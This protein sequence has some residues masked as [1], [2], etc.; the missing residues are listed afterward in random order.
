MGLRI[1]IEILVAAFILTFTAVILMHNLKRR[2][3]S[4]KALTESE[5]RFRTLINGMS[6]FICIKDS[7]G[8]LVD[9]ND[10]VVKLL[11]LDKTT[12]KGLSCEDIA[13]EKP[14]LKPLID[15]IKHYEEGIWVSKESVSFEEPLTLAEG[16]SGL[17]DFTMLP[18]FK[19]NGEK[20]GVIII[21]KDLTDRKKTKEDLQKN[22]EILR[23]TLNATADGIL[24]VT[25]SREVVDCNPLFQKMWKI[26]QYIIDTRDEVELLNFVS[27]QLEN[28][29]DFRSWVNNCYKINWAESWTAYFK[30]GRVFEVYSEPLIRKSIA[31]GRVWSFKD[32]TARKRMERELIESEERYRRLVEL[33]PD[34]IYMSID[35]SNIFSNSTGARLL[36]VDDPKELVGKPILGFVYYDYYDTTNKKLPDANGERTVLPLIEEKLIKKDGSIVDIEVASTTYEYKGKTAILSVVRDVTERK[37]TEELRKK[38][39]ENSR[40]LTEAIEYDKLK[41]EFFANISHEFRTPLNIILGAQQLFDFVLKDTVD[42]DSKLKIDKYLKI[43]KQNCYRLLRLVNNLID[44]T[45]IDAGFFNIQLKNHNIV[46]VVEEI[47][48]SVAEYIENKGVHL[49]FDTDVEEKLLACDADKIERIML[50][51][52]SN[53]TKFTEPEDSIE[54]IVEDKGSIVAITVRDTGIGIPKDKQELIFER[55]RQV[56]KSFIR[57]HEGSGIGLSIVKSLAELHGGR[58]YMESELGEGTSFTIELPVRV[59]P[60]EHAEGTMENTYQSKIERINVEFSDIYL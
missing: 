42:G 25:N 8:R 21:G 7:A 31:E 13:A 57:N 12:S 33:S 54:V 51:L 39:E 44:I 1:I 58:V 15:K 47:T 4:E 56:D 38:M 6:D 10:A 17:F 41:T 11:G 26:P 28:P 46:S 43:M 27:N 50:N 48:L 59:V 14:Y 16:S 37:R 29:N 5:E 30:D 45:R 35:G 24:V 55:F 60:D 9:G 20:N 18:I 34:A 32:I 22:E 19:T 23:A 49:Q 40:L 36:G 2:K 52:L 53:A 3:A